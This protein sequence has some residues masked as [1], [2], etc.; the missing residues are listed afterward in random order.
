[1]IA[2]SNLLPLMLVASALVCSCGKGP[3]PGISH[4]DTGGSWPAWNG[5]ETVAQYASRARLEP[6]LT[7]HLGNRVSLALVL[8][9]AGTFLMGSP[10][11]EEGRRVDRP[12][13]GPGPIEVETL[14]EVTLTRPFYMGKYEVTDKQF[15]QV[16]HG[17]PQ[18]DGD[19]LPVW[20]VNWNQAQAFC[21]AAAARTGRAVRLPTEAEWEFACR[22]GTRTRFCSG[23]TVGDLKKIG[24]ASYDGKFGSAEGFK[25]VGPFVPNA[26]GLYDMH[27]NVEEWCQDWQ[28]AYPGEPAKD[29]RGPA[30]GRCR[31]VRGGCRAS[32]PA[33][34]R[35]AYR[36]WGPPSYTDYAASG[37]RVVVEIFRRAAKGSVP[38]GREEAGR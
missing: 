28:G 26:W 3:P 34:C 15:S 37:F 24:W 19:D 7:L 1:M 2:V 6:T 11:D 30:E 4:D 5:T 21:R 36:D 22:A 31:I 25:P 38:P 8:V 10:E 29:P 35:S 33:D 12:R 23:N 32:R 20:G 16:V 14:H 17:R 9:P 13:H 18:S 27:G